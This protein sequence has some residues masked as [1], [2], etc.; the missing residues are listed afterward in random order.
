MYVSM[1][2]K[3]LSDTARFCS[4]A[5][6]LPGIE[7]I[8][9][10]FWKILLR[11]LSVSERPIYNVLLLAGTS[12][13]HR[14]QLLLAAGHLLLPSGGGG[15]ASVGAGQPAGP[16]VGGQMEVADTVQ[17]VELLLTWAAMQVCTKALR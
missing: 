8:A 6:G 7:R 10:H 5:L 17:G 3:L 9:T 12:S 15:G 14:P 16:L 4:K 2:N 11:G 1:V 13:G